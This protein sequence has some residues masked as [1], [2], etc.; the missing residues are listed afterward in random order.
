MRI[1]CCYSYMGGM[2]C[3]WRSVAD[4]EWVMG[5]IATGGGMEERRGR[6]RKAVCFLLIF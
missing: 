2:C 4:E 3:L 6:G 5:G 1:L